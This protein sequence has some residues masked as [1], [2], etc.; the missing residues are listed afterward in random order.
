M[1]KILSIDGGGIRGIIPSIILNE[2]E[3]K[4]G[5]KVSEIF[6]LITGTSTG[7]ILALGL[8]KPDSEGKPQ[9]SAEDMTD[10]YEQEG[11]KIFP[12]SFWR[13]LSTVGGLLDERYPHGPIEEVF[14][15]LFSETTIGKS[16]TKV[17][18]S[19]YDIEHRNPFFF[20]SWRPNI[21]PV[22]MREAARATSAAP[23]YFEP[24]QLKVGGKL[25]TLVDG[26]V[27]INNPAV[28]AYAEAK[29]LFPGEDILVVSLG[30]GELTRPIHYEEAK[31]WGLAQWAL[32]I[33]SVVFDG[34][35]DGADYQ[36]RQIL[37]DNFYRFQTELDI[38][39]D[40]MDNVSRSNMEALKLE[41]QQ[42]L[43]ERQQNLDELCSILINNS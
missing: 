5:K 17:L 6:D 1:K 38:A 37:G 24:L 29:K 40:D 21:K 8:C 42:I 16:I 31:D 41:A 34:V 33:L 43:S 15:E 7:G 4:T 25:L 11:P 14:D 28:S 27:F 18:I 12:R 20:K 35:S 3:K 32:P 26:G 22:K 2:I 39:S 13:G 36:L 19:S 23:T 9:Y 30:T 10:F